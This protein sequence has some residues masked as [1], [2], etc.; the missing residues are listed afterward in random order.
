MMGVISADLSSLSPA[1]NLAYLIS[2][3]GILLYYCELLS[4][5]KLPCSAGLIEDLV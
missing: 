1:G 5:H 4:V 3:F 2:P